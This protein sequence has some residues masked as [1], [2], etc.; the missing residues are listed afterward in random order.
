MAPLFYKRDVRGVPVGWVSMIQKSISEVAPE[1]TMNRML[2]DYIER[3]YTGL[4][5]RTL[6]LRENEYEMA[7][8]LATWKRKILN[9]WSQI[10]V[11]SVVY[12]DTNRP[13]I[14]VGTNYISEVVLDLKTLSSREVGIEYVTG[15]LDES[16]VHMKIVSIQEYE[17]VKTEGSKAW[18][19]LETIPTEPGIF[20]YGI[21]LYPRN[22]LLAHKQDMGLIRWI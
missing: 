4:Y 3:F 18:Y 12:P 2:R 7:S 22:D 21:R 17:L 13:N 8:R 14:T 16:G 5:K 1:F 11:V 19:R 10:E 6:K 20:D 15:D 9:A